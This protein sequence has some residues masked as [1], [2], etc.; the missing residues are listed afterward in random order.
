[1]QAAATSETGRSDASLA[2]VP[3]E[4]LQG[5]RILITADDF[6]WTDGHNLAVER[7]ARAG[8]LNRAS[9]LATGAA[10]A[11]AVIAARRCPRLGVGVHL[12]LCEGRPLSESAC[13]RP[14]PAPTLAQGRP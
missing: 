14:G 12:T 2:G 11:G 10:F 3:H 8:T 9:L 6:G 7:A 1:M 5:R 4:L 13:R